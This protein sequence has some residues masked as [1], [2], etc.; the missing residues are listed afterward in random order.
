MK[1]VAK[2]FI[3]SGIVL[4][5]S[6]CVNTMPLISHAHMGHSLTSWHDTPGNDG[7]L[8]VAKKEV[9]I[10]MREA[11][12]AWLAQNDPNKTS[13]HLNNAVNALNPDV[14]PLGTGEGYGA[15][16]ALEG[17]VEHIE[18]AA[19][20]DDASL[21]MVSSVAVLGEQGAAI[22]QRLKA[23]VEL[24]RDSQNAD[25]QALGNLAFKL[26]HQLKF[27]T[28]GRDLDSSG[29][30]EMESTEIGLNHFDAQLQAM[31]DRETDPPYEPLERKYVLGLV[32]LPNGSWDFRIGRPLRRSTS[33]SGYAS[34]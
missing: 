31:L 34:Y 19:S 25:A 30:I 6:G 26:R 9:A 18:Y 29:G 10:A 21:N 24:A 8:V 32:R 3:F 5:G 28:E 13:Y 16:R 4:L 20:S 14:Q 11:D 33:G 7:L 22:I 12:L 1:T 15:V 23:A 2:L 17:A 27:A